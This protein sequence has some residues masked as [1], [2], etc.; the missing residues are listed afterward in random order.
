VGAAGALDGDAPFLPEGGVSRGA[1]VPPPHSGEQFGQG[2]A[3]FALQVAGQE[4]R[5]RREGAGFGERLAHGAHAGDPGFPQRGVHRQVIAEELQAVEQGMDFG[6]PGPQPDRLEK[7]DQRLI[8]LPRRQF[9]QR[10][11]SL[12]KLEV[13]N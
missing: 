8:R 1:G 13:R 9:S 10:D 5:R 11:D 4:A 2:R 12:S 6:R 3:G 7:V